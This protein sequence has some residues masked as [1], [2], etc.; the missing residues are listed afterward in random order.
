MSPEHQG[1]LQGSGCL[2]AVLRSDSDTDRDV[3]NKAI[4]IFLQMN[5][6]KAT[7]STVSALL[8]LPGWKSQQ[9]SPRLQ[10]ICFLLKMLLVA[11]Q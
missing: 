4:G 1:S 2:W 9:P 3:R 11:K 7:H 10:R 6:Q 5:V 8:F